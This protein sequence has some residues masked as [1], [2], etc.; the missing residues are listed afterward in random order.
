MPYG[1]TS[2]LLN[3]IG[4]EMLLP[5]DQS[6]AVE[7]TLTYYQFLE[8]HW[9]RIGTDNPL[10]RILREIGRRTRL[11]GRFQTDN[12]LSTWPLPAEAYC[13]QRLVEQEIT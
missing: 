6:R 5:A 7:E 2:E 10:E 11:S 12:Q 3:L 4:F 8:E 9:C 1:R 13:R